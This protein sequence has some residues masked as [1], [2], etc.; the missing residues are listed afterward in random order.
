LKA[1]ARSQETKTALKSLAC[2]KKSF[3]SVTFLYLGPAER[4]GF[5]I[6]SVLLSVYLNSLVLRIFDISTKRNTPLD[7]D[8]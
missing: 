4:G 5:S 8:L 2:R 3:N 7:A 1:R 6:L